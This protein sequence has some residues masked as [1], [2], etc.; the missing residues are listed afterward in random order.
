MAWVLGRT[1]IGVPPD[2]AEPPPRASDVETVGTDPHATGILRRREVRRCRVASAASWCLPSLQPG[3]EVARGGRV[4]GPRRHPPTPQPGPTTPRRRLR[5]YN[6]H[7]RPSCGIASA[8]HEPSRRYG[9]GGRADSIA[10]TGVGPTAVIAR[11]PDRPTWASRLSALG[12]APAVTGWRAAR[13]ADIY[14]RV[15]WPVVAGAW[16]SARNR[17]FVCTV[18][19]CR[20]GGPHPLVADAGGLHTVDIA[21]LP[22]SMLT[23]AEATGRWRKPH[24]VILPTGVV[25]DVVDA[26]AGVGRRIAAPSCAR[27]IRHPWPSW[28]SAGSSS[29]H[30][31]P[32]T[33][34]RPLRRQSV[35]GALVHTWGSWVMLPP[36]KIGDRSRCRWLRP[37]WSTRWWMPPLVATRAALRN[38]GVRTRPGP[39]QPVSSRPPIGVAQRISPS[40]T[41][42]V[43]DIPAAAATRW[44][45]T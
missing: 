33:T 9:A 40:T 37:P 42:S 10:G 15:G 6:G 27:V 20:T 1:A 26:P 4:R 28:P 19:A 31:A 17:R 23:S 32:A 44:D 18:D 8:P 38:F 24:A 2:T 12:R 43:G 35:V 34:S 5:L 3:Q 11:R 22:T 29:S 25:C 36:S 30:P 45:A 14:R 39:A 16:W 13:A 21:T 41:R 7:V